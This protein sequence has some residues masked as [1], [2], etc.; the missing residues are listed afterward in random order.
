MY[1]AVDAWIPANLAAPFA[2][3]LNNYA[4]QERIVDRKLSINPLHPRHL[5]LKSEA[6]GRRGD[7]AGAAESIEKAMFYGETIPEVRRWRLAA[8]AQDKSRHHEMLGDI[9]DALVDTDFHPIIMEFAIDKL[10]W[11]SLS[12]R[13]W[14]NGTEHSHYECR[15]LRILS[16]AF[17]N[18]ARHSNRAATLG[19]SNSSLQRVQEIIAEADFDACTGLGAL[20]P[21]D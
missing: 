12:F 21:V 13:Y 16:N 11:S 3:A 1:D 17:N 20:R 15:R 10:V 8:I 5:A 2:R 14:A 4:V 18:C 6:Q 19:C 7:F 9:E